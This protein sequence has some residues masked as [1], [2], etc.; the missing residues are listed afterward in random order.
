MNVIF[1]IATREMR[2]ID[3]LSHYNS[4]VHKL[5]NSKFIFTHIKEVYD[6]VNDC[7]SYEFGVFVDGKFKLLLT[8]E[9]EPIPE[10]NENMGGVNIQIYIDYPEYLNLQ[11]KQKKV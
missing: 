11:I 6:D 3:E 1:E 5:K 10:G 2:K 7:P 4:I 9:G 8:G